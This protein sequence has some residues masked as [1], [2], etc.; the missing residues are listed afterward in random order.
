VKT[1]D[2]LVA[3]A[4]T[5]LA[6]LFIQVLPVSFSIAVGLSMFPTIRSGDVLVCIRKEYVPVTNGSIAGYRIGWTNVVHRVVDIRGDTYVFR[7][8]NNVHSE[9]VPSSN[10]VCRVVAIIPM[11]IWVTATAAAQA[12]T[13]LYAV[14]HRNSAAV[15][16]MVALM[17]LAISIGSS[18][19]SASF[20]DIAI[21]KPNPLPVVDRIYMNGTVTTV[22][23]SVHLNGY[24]GCFTQQGTPITCI[25]D[26]NRVIVESSLVEGLKIIYRPR[27]PYNVTVVYDLG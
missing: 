25:V 21:V 13:A 4:A 7:G 6:L 5:F 8:D 20:T 24:V 16:R 26:G 18:G 27:T 1:S 3:L 10:V 22:V 9:H 17:V 14:K 19:L 15:A 11:P 2:I 23:F 12:A